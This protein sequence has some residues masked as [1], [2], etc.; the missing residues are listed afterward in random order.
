ML[1]LF[2]NKSVNT[3]TSSMLLLFFH[4]IVR[5]LSKYEIKEISIIAFHLDRTFI[6]NNIH[7][8]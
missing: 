5:I 6:T 7:T 3:V 1:A 8:L 2:D 4:I